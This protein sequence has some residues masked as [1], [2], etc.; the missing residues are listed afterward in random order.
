MV[1]RLMPD[2]LESI[3]AALPLLD[4][5]EAIIL[6]DSIILPMSIKLD[7]P[8]LKPVG[9]TMNF[10]TD[11]NEREVFEASN[12]AAVKSMRRQSRV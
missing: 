7:A 2:S 1:K 6:G 4:V 5:G 3:T 9:A 10:W 8:R 12:V 11:W